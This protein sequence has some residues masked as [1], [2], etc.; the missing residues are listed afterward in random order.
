MIAAT[1]WTKRMQSQLHRL[2]RWLYHR[3]IRW[4]PDKPTV[5]HR[6]KFGLQ[7]ESS[8]DIPKAPV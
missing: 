5:R 2:N 1:D 7:M 3:Y 6:C 4:L 8:E